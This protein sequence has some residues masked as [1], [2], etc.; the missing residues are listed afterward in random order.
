MLSDRESFNVEALLT[1]LVS[2]VHHTV[3]GG[4]QTAHDEKQA[5]NTAC[6]SMG[7]HTVRL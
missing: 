4:F 2:I 3:T 7:G 6:Y 5:H 1:V